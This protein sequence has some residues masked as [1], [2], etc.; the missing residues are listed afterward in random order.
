MTSATIDRVDLDYCEC[1]GADAPSERFPVEGASCA[2]CGDCKGRYIDEF[3]AAYT[4]Q[5]KP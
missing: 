2:M 5:V 3:I 4:T 1:C